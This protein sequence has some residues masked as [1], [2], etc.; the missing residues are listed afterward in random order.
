MS[1]VAGQ[2]VEDDLL[3]VSD[4]HRYHTEEWTLDSACSYHYTPHRSWFAT[5]TKS[6]EGSVTLGDNHLCEVAGIGTVKVR[7]L[8]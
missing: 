5:Y 2:Q 4:G 1:V 8:G 6:D 3:V 7:W